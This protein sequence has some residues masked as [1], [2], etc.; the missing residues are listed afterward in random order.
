[1]TLYKILENCRICNSNQLICFLDLG[2]TELADRFSLEHELPSQKLTFPLGINSCVNCGW[3]QLTVTVNPGLMYAKNYP[4][5]SRT[6]ETGRKHWA[7]LAEETIG[8]IEKPI[9]KIMVLDIGSN[10]GALLSEYKKF[11]CRVIGVDPSVE[12]SNIA[13]NHGIENYI[14]FFDEQVVHFLSKL[15]FKPDIITSTNSFAH[16]DNLNEWLLNVSKALDANGLLVIEAP[17][18]LKLLLENQFDTIYHEHLSYVFLSPLIKFF[19]KFGFSI[20]HVEELDIHGGSLRIYATTKAVEIDKSVQKLIDEETILGI[21]KKESLVRFSKRVENNRNE[22]REF[23]SSIS[24]TGKT[25]GIISAPA[26]GMTY[27]SYCGLSEFD[28]VG[29]SDKNPLK[30]GKIAPGTGMRVITDQQLIELNPDYLLILA[31]NFKKE[32]VNNIRNLGFKKKFVVCIPSLEVI[33]A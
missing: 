4:Y 9:H 32:V 24:K 3:L 25:I 13:K 16:T 10:T 29:I 11:G 7:S 20:F 12:A 14:G 28:F 22:I 18:A 19:N 23:L 15:D 8:L 1:M 27:F 21:T 31:W 6:T 5:D 17:H 2:I 26:K 30:I 33:D